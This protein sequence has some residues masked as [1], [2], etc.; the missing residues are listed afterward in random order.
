MPLSGI[1]GPGYLIMKIDEV[2]VVQVRSKS[3]CTGPNLG[4][5][6]AVLVHVRSL[7]PETF[8]VI[9]AY[10]SEQDGCPQLSREELIKNS[11]I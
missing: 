9:R 3:Q 11:I 5:T 8:T 2:T 7:S 4:G 6:W 1:L 10:H